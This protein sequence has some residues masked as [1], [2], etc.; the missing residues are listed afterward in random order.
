MHG[1]SGGKLAASSDLPVAAGLGMKWAHSVCDE[2]LPVWRPT[3]WRRAC[4]LDSLK[5]QS[6]IATQAV[7]YSKSSRPV[8]YTRAT[9]ASLS[10]ISRCNYATRPCRQTQTG[11][12]RP[13][14]GR[15]TSSYC[16]LGMSH[17]CIT[18]RHTKACY[19]ARRRDDHPFKSVHM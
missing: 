9:D 15:A 16:V 14:R 13:V 19:I 8:L 4:T 5:P 17:I 6:A 7:H 2:P 3:E 11:P 10:G 1:G 12:V 18:L